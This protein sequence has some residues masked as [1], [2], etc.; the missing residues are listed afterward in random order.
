[1][2][3][4]GVKERSRTPDVTLALQGGLGNQLFQWAFA[5]S[6]RD[7]GVHVRVDTV[8]CRGN[9]Q[10]A[11]E[12]LLDGFA[13]ADGAG[14]FLRFA[15]QKVAP[16]FFKPLV[17]EQQFGFDAELAALARTQRCFI[18]GYFQSP[19]YFED[20]ADQVRDRI[21]TFLGSSLTPAGTSFRDEL[22][23]DHSVAVHVRRGDYVSNPAAAAHHGTLQS[24][25][26][27]R[28]LEGLRGSGARV[29][30][31]SD[32]LDWTRKNLATPG[33]QVCPPS[34]TTGAAG[35]IAL[36][37]ACQT[38]I[39]ANSSFSWWAGWLGKQ[40]D[41]G[42]SVFAPRRWFV[43]ENVSTSDLLPESWVTL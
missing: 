29:V 38:R 32:D 37:A 8:R 7:D 14:A 31:F 1:M 5:T 26:Y 13:R 41:L 42:G 11:I 23:R 18:S 19:R 6:L 39:I 34:L 22:T 2:S 15:A 16:R 27:D 33:E 4:A 21:L 30:W 36:M 24:S 3:V 9:R 10:L 28:A 12:P 40:P 25:Y 35:E 20:V 43:N 17:E